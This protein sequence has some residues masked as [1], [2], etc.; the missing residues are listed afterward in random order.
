M[1]TRA[2]QPYKNVHVT[3][4]L[5]GSRKESRASRFIGIGLV[6]P[7]PTLNYVLKFDSTQRQA[8]ESEYS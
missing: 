8:G 7:G 3:V 5:V 4:S 6:A 2:C 1:G